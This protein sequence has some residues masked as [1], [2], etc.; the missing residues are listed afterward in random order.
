MHL[1]NPVHVSLNK[2][3]SIQCVARQSRPPVKILIAINGHLINDE[4]KYKTEIIQIP[5]N[6]P[7]SGDSGDAKKRV[8]Y[9]NSMSA[10]SAEQMR[11]SYYDTITNITIDDITMKMQGQTVE[12]FAYSLV[13]NGNNN[14][15][16]NNI[17]NINNNRYSSMNTNKPLNLN[18][19]MSIKSVIQVDC[20]S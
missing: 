3:S 4:S 8:S 14:H 11:H 17:Y 10:I 18:N 7:N 9:I 12:C 20:K 16:H 19:V 2:P 6:D 13:H 1:E 5:I 15:H